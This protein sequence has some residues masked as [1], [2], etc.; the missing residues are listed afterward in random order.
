MRKTYQKPLLFAEQFAMNEHISKGCA[1]I[2]NFGNGCPI[3]E[4]GV[5]FFTNAENSGC[6]EDAISMME[7]AGLDPATVTVE[8]LITVL[9][10]TCYNSFADF[11][12]LFVS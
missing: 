12:Q 7:F 8:D 4:A 1:Y 5:I 2:S 6:N 9:H 10:P 11:S 3:D